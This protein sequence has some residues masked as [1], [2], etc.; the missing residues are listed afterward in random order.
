M[1]LDSVQFD[2]PKPGKVFV[3]F[4][5]FAIAN[6][7]VRFTF[8][9]S[10]HIGWTANARNS[11]IKVPNS[12]QNHANF[13][14]AMVYDVTPSPST[15][16]AIAQNYVE[17]DG[18]GVG[19][20]YGNLCAVY[21][22]DNTVGLEDE[23]N[24]INGFELYQNYPNPFNPVTTIRYDIPVTTQVELSVYTIT[25]QKIRTLISAEQKPGTYKV[26]FNAGELSSG[27]YIIKLNTN[28]FS[29]SIKAV[30]LK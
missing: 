23:G 10:D 1:A 6:V 30:L 12:D 8:A 13:A 9:A 24:M 25:G 27:I 5:G 2:F 20:V 7:G 3:Y 22:P 15:F 29:K 26:N 21:F 17:T 19:S 18:S 28:Y 4:D 14:H 11:N 16:Y